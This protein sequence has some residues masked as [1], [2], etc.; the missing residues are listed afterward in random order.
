VLLFSGE[1]RAEA[2][3]IVTLVEQ[4]VAAQR[5]VAC[6]A[7]RLACL[8]ACC[9]YKAV[10]SLRVANKTHLNYTLHSISGVS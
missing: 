7:D 8:L 5:T 3:H 1:R 10:V 2:S 6:E 9:A 4:V